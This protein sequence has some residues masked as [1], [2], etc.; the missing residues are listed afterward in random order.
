MNGNLIRNTV[1]ANFTT[2]ASRKRKLQVN[3]NILLFTLMQIALTLDFSVLR[4]NAYTITSIVT[5]Y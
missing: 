5:C 2:T 1:V 3:Y 4:K